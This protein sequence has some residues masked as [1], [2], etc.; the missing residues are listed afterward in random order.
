MN[1][2]LI[3]H[4]THDHIITP[5]LDLHIPG[6]TAWYAGWALRH[7]LNTLP[8]GYDSV[9]YHLITSVSQADQSSI[10]ALTEAGV[11]VHNIPSPTTVYFENRYGQNMN[12]RQ[13][14]VLSRAQ[15]FTWEN[16]Q[17][18]IASI[19]AA[20]NGH[21][22][23]TDHD[24]DNIAA[25]HDHH[26]MTVGNDRPIFL[27]GSLLA[28]DFPLEV[29]RQL[30]A[31]GQVVVDVQGYLREV[32]GEEVRAIDW[33][34]KRQAL[35]Y[36]DIL[37]TNEYEMEVL[38]GYNEPLRAARQLCEWGA[39]E[40]LLTFGDLGSIICQSAAETVT[41]VTIPA[42]T[43][44]PMVDATGCG[45]TYTTAYILR[46]AQGATTLDAGR[47]AAATATIK[48]QRSGP[49]NGTFQ[50]VLDVIGQAK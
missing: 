10:D 41:T 47:F 14:R 46:R 29:I 15:A 35:P 19:L 32:V 49:F 6:G 3:G 28:D 12:N 40:V 45:D 16:L 22:A 2:I 11:Q 38:T 42:Y 21:A 43:P 34:E 25:D 27:L 31:L 39:G 5:E 23:M 8:Q 13:Q 20:D 7:L 44:H 26:T 17:P 37:K 50:D 9:P 48:L 18:I 1:I 33:S 4:I 30:H 36:V 24:P